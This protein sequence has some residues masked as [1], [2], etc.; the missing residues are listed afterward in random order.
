MFSTLIELSVE[1]TRIIL[2]IN[3]FFGV[4]GNLLNII[5]LT[6]PSLYKNVST[7][8]FLALAMNN[9]FGSTF[10]L[11]ISLLANGYQIDITL[12]S[13]ISCK[14]VQYLNELCT[15]LSSYYIV[16]VFR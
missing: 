3:I 16:L 12:F 13:L 7:H 9:L 11:I 8:Y 14:I 6:R 1:L 15:V 2:P 5:V 4:I 10:N